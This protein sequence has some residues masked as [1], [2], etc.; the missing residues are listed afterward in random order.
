MPKQFSTPV[1]ESI[2]NSVPILP[3]ML[4]INNAVSSAQKH[5][6]T[7]KS[8]KCFLLFWSI[9]YN[10]LQWNLSLPSLRTM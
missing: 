6:G 7:L 5:S 9:A 8:I 3:V 1:A 2:Y 10:F 4:L